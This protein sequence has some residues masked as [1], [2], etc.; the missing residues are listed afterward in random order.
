MKQSG[1]TLIELLISV[2]IA[3]LVL[4]G[5]LN[6]TQSALKAWVIN[7]AKA[8]VEQVLRIGL[9]TL[10]RDARYATSAKTMVLNGVLILTLTDPL[11]DILD[12]KH[13]PD[14]E[15]LSRQITNS[16]G[17]NAGYQAIAGDGTNKKPGSVVII[18]NPDQAP[19]FAV[20]GKLV[21]VTLT[22]L[23]RK[24]GVRA[25]MHTKIFCL[26]I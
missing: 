19:L 11:G 1:F 8:E 6:L 17:N 20:N 3:A 12:F 5:A 22:A 2:S 14:T 16:D 25:T 10:T 13:E 24:T 26:N 18:A 7:R 4:A 21:S 9:D 15:A 23:H